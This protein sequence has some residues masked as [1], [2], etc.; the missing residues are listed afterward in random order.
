[1]SD[2]FRE[3]MD[4]GKLWHVYLGD[5]NR[6]PPGQGRL[7][8]PGIVEA[9]RDTGYQ[10]YLSAELL[11]RPH[12]DAAGAATIRYMRNLVPAEIPPMATI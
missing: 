2:C 3:G 6:L 10:G 4:A 12:A 5:S 8:F 7:D 11:R 9:L 1:M